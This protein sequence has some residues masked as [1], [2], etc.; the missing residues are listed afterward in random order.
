MDEGALMSIAGDSQ[1]RTEALNRALRIYTQFISIN[2]TYMVNCYQKIIN[3]KK[4]LH[5]NQ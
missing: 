4:Q 2:L 3:G 5:I 1:E